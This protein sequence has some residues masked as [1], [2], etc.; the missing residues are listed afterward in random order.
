M[1]DNEQSQNK[2]GSG[3]AGNPIKLDLKKYPVVEVRLDAIDFEDTEFQCRAGM[4]KAAV[5]LLKVSIKE[6]GQ[7][8]P[9]YLLDMQNGQKLR[10]LRGFHKS[11]A[12]KELGMETCY[13]IILPV[14][15][16]GPDYKEMA[17]KISLTDNVDCKTL[18]DCD[19]MVSCWRLYEFN[20]NKNINQLSKEVGASWP[21]TQ[22]YMALYKAGQEIRDAVVNG[23]LPIKKTVTFLMV[24][25]AKPGAQKGNQTGF[26]SP[27]DT[28]D[29]LQIDTEKL[30]ILLKA[31]KDPEPKKACKAA[32]AGGA[33]AGSGAA[34]NGSGQMGAGKQASM[35]E[36]EGL[37]N[38]LIKL[39]AKKPDDEFKKAV[40]AEIESLKE[41]VFNEFKEQKKKAQKALADK[42]AGKPVA[43]Q[44]T[45]AE[46]E[47]AVNKKQE[48][49]DNNQTEID[50]LEHTVA[51]F[52]TKGKDT[53][54]L[55][56]HLEGLKAE[57]KKL[58]AELS[59]LKRQLKSAGAAAPQGGA[60]SVD[61]SNVAAELA[62]PDSKGVK[63]KTAKQASQLQDKA[64]PNQA[65]P[66]S[67][68]P[69]PQSKMEALARRDWTEFFN[70]MPPA[71]QIPQVKGLMS[72][73]NII[74]SRPGLPE[75]KRQAEAQ[76]LATLQAYLD[77]LQKASPQA[78]SYD[79]AEVEA[80]KKR[81]LELV[82]RMSKKDM[83]SVKAQYEADVVTNQ[84]E[85][86]KPDTN[87]AK[88]AWLKAWIQ[89]EQ[90][91]IEAINKKLS[92]Q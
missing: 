76:K 33:Q 47:E 69:I 68:I 71:M 1:S 63:S 11:V 42:P 79:L 72:A 7:Q 38:K 57:Q 31:L 46:L 4:D 89:M 12:M 40:S 6:K 9:L 51:D 53:K 2:N 61:S 78:Q 91:V 15:D 30:D 81:A 45:A 36:F 48:Q 90:E 58:K 67:K 75:E 27:S 64:D 86:A 18:N 80:Q 8:T 21:M 52:T 59:K 70:G 77:E 66:T 13:A 32:L 17:F 65:N 73:T 43:K 74:L 87:E 84:R 62:L 5:E 41:A 34:M 35:P 60:L 56:E 54:D 28:C 82:N 39:I 24:N 50:T 92:G 44:P 14:S 26:D 25:A 19:K 20:K 88:A 85:L 10:R 23:T 83:E 37:K 55:Q 16:L 29:N 3:Q 22:T 49:A